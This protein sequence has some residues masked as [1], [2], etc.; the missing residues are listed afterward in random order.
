MLSEK[1][2]DQM[3]S[4]IEAISE[5]HPYIA[6]I[7]MHEVTRNLFPSDPFI[8]FSSDEH[9]LLRIEKVVQRA[10][11]IAQAFGGIGS[12]GD[13]IG[14]A[15]KV[16]F[17]D[18][19]D[20]TGDV[21]GKV[22]KDNPPSMVDAARAIIVERFSKNQIP[23]SMIE[24]KRVLDMGAGSGRYSCALSLLGAAEVV[25]VDYGDT[26]LEKG[27]QLAA[28]HGI[29]NVVFQ[30]ADFLDLPFE[31]ES[32]DFVFC[33]GT[34]HHS[35]D[36]AKA[37]AELYRVLKTGAHSWFYVYGAKGI[38]WTTLRKFNDLM[39]RV[40][41]SKEYAIRV[42]EMI[43]MPRERHIFIDHWYVPI[44]IHTTKDEFEALLEKIGFS[45]FRRCPQGRPTDFDHL[46][47]YGSDDDRAMW[48]DGELRYLVTK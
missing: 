15:S 47:V 13:R 26:G 16:T 44:F 18:V 37:S 6:V 45:Q 28:E 11:E 1:N 31:D 4:A 29:E 38:F 36:M 7:L 41:I 33:N 2:I 34:V 21:Y 12:Y 48:G 40:D 20:E 5:T 3:V 32:F 27:R 14:S 23:L 42:L 17:D 19:R 25:A 43:G 24:K 39:K 46:V 10:T 8:P 9:G 30:K 22:W 35:E